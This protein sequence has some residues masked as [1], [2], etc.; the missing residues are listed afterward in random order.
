M[1]EDVIF[2][3]IL[4]PG[5]AIRILLAFLGTGVAAYYDVFNKKNIPDKFLYAFLALA[6]LINLVFYDEALFMFSLGIA[7]FLSAIGYLFYRVGQLGGADLFVLAAIMLLLPINPSYAAMP[8]NLPFIFSV[9]IFSGVLFA[10]YVLLYF[11]YKVTQVESKPKWLFLLIL[12]PYGLFA[13]FFIN[14]FLFSWVFFAFI[15]ISIFASV[16]F[17]MFRDSLNQLLAEEMPVS[18]LEPEDVLALEIMNKD[19]VERYKIPR[20]MSQGEIDRLRKT[21]VGEVW[22]YTKL[23]PF[24]PFILAGMVLS[25]LFARSLLLL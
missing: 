15:T 10:L 20:L 9:F 24:I 8:F 5:E 21:K 11:G 25:M 12:I 18:Q 13:W 23:P 4:M 7:V 6:F 1:L 17:M 19:M 16:F 3:Q 2:G 14:S 22:V